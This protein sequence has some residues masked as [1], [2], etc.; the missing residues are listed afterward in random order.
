M[1]IVDHVNWREL[2]RLVEAHQ[3]NREAHTPV[4][5]LF[6][7]WARRPHAVVGA[8]LD[9]AIA[10][11]GSES[12]VVADPF[13][14]GGTVAFEAVRRGL[15]T[16]AQE[17]YPWPSLGLAICLGQADTTTFGNAGAWL[18]H[19]LE[20]HRRQ[21]WREDKGIRWEITH[22]LRV[23][24]ASCLLCQSRIYLFRGI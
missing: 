11:F 18:L 22:I 1:A 15:P 13:S 5:S 20:S 6:R 10:E 19:R 9:A 16:Y 14:G 3:R 24:I 4:I 12:F 7:W 21:Y 8:I 17:L 2:D 23:R